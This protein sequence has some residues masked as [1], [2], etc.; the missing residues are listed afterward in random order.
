MVES[1]VRFSVD[2]IEVAAIV[3]LVSGIVLSCAAAAYRSRTGDA[4]DVYRSLRQ[5]IGRS[6][7]LALELLVAAD[8]VATVAIDPTLQ[9]V[10]V[11]AGRQRRGSGAD[12]R[13]ARGGCLCLY[14]PP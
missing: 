2:L 8:I 9:S 3:V 1:L 7:L 14:P 5:W 4:P 6:I 13:L 10:A 11:L 12:H